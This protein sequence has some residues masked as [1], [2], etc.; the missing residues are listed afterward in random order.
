MILSTLDI[1]KEKIIKTILSYIILTLILFIFSIIYLKF[2]FG[3]I[4]L[5]MKYLSLIPLIFGVLGY[6]ILFIFK[7]IKY[8]K[9]SFDLYNSSIYTLILGFLLQGILEIAGKNSKYIKIFF[10][11]APILFIIS[12]ISLILNQKNNTSK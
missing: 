6:L 2:S 11:I 10:I 1:N 9:I 3:V 4:S 8:S 7:N 5:F 12:I